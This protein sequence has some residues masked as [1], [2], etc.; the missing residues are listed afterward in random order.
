MAITVLFNGLS[1][2]S[3]FRPWRLGA[4]REKL[5]TLLKQFVDVTHTQMREVSAIR[6]I[7][8]PQRAQQPKRYSS[9]F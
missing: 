4:A 7:D 9:S 5:E 1:A 3:R 8:A 6:P 2:Y